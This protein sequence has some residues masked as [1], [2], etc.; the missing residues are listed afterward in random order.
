MGPRALLLVLSLVLAAPLAAEAQPARTAPRIGVL[1]PTSDNPNL[2]GFR[3]GLRDLGYVEGHSILI[4]YRYA[5]G[6]DELLPGLAAELVQLEVDVIVTQGML[7]AR[8][9][10]Y[11]SS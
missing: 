5:D 2:D 9:A 6:K 3:Q 7:A 8:V 4:E 1:W 11:S 10:K